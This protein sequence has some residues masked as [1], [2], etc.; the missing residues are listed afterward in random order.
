M[1]DYADV[2]LPVVPFTET[3]GTFVNAEGRWQSFEAAVNPL[4]EARPAWK[5]LRVLGNL[6]NAHGFDYVTC[7]EV[8]DELKRAVDNQTSKNE[9]SAE[10]PMQ[11]L[12]AADSTLVR[13][14]EVPIY[15]VDA[16]VRRASALQQTQEAQTAAAYVN[17]RVAAQLAIVA[18]QEVQASQGEARARL[19]VVIDE[20]VPDGCVMIPAGLAGS[21]TLGAAFGAIELARA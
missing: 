19:T 5:V 11:R 8:R 3:A 4:A 18:G 6:F 20:R 9:R 13:I 7:H 10:K 16:L 1:E 21:A 12:P 14:S 2:M 15:A 17:R